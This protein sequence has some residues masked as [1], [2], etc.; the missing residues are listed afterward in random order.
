MTRTLLALSVVCFST[1]LSASGPSVPI[2]DRA[3]GAQTVVVAKVLEV[4]PTFEQNKFGDQLIVSHATLQV[5]EALKGAP[6]PVISLDVEGGTIGDLTLHVSDMEPI[7][8]GDRAVFF[9]ERASNGVN[10]PHL[11]GKGILK[12]DPAN[13]VHGSAVTLDEVRRQIQQAGR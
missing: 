3:K 1:A 6:A 7:S 10:V 11:R 9:L 8:K 5:E 12:L 13:R 4:T 2:G